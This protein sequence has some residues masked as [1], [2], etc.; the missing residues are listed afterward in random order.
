MSMKRRLAASLCLLLA[1]V[2]LLSTPAARACAL[3]PAGCRPMVCCK[4]APQAPDALRPRCC[5]APPAAVSALPEPSL[6]KERA[7]E[8][9]ASLP[10]AALLALR[11][12]T[13]APRPAPA[14]GAAQ[15]G[16]PDPHL[17]RSTV[18]RI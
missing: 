4:Q 1:A 7:H 11:A 18:L 15:R 12:P 5:P 13:P 9:P 14:G 10:A 3:Q 17:L 16:L 6:K 8:G 2:A